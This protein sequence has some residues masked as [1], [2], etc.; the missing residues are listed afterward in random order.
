MGVRDVEMPHT[1]SRV[2]P[3]VASFE[4]AVS[5]AMGSIGAVPCL[6]V[7][8]SGGAD[9]TAMLVSLSRLCP[10]MG[11]S[12]VC[13]HISHGLRPEYEGREDAAA[14]S[15]LCDSLS[16]SLSI[17][18]AA[19]G[20]ISGRSA[21]EGC[22]IEAAA[23]E[24]RM[25]ALRREADRLGAKRIAV[26]HTRDDA[27]EHVLI[28]VLRGSGPAG[29]AAMPMERG[30]LV[31]PL[32]RLGRA[33]VLAYLDSLGIRYRTDST[34]VDPSFLRNRVRLGLVPLL[35]T[36]FPGWQGSIHSLAR[37]QARTAEFLSAEAEK[38][39]LWTAD[40]RAFNAFA[41]DEVNFFSQA[42]ILR[43]EALFQVVDA[44]LRLDTH[45]TGCPQAD[46]AP[47]GRKEPRREA[48]AV[49]ASGTVKAMDLGPVLVERRDSR[50]VATVRGGHG[51]ET[52]FAIVIREPG[53]LE[54]DG[55]CF[56]VELKET[57][58]G[59]SCPSGKVVDDSDGFINRVGV[60]LPFVIRSCS[61]QDRS[62]VRL[63]N[64]DGAV[65]PEPFAL[66]EDSGG[67]A[68]LISRD[69][70]GKPVLKELVHKDRPAGYARRAFF[71]IL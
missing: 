21:T 69:R 30:P 9:S 42:P 53:V 45:K 58:I 5:L 54:I 19:P 2:N 4:A 12:L 55:T 48:I 35:D 18:S 3:A 50:I 31:R 60:E 1:S 41:T 20:Y 71:S 25:D 10:Q 27:L 44:L 13:V 11:I 66:V 61:S 17:I 63:S 28:R 14:V 36:D 24:F 15:S 6:A 67:I 52:G 51:S 68:A 22:G 43:E 56:L 64:K 70:K 23:R 47:R 40:N 37:T 34:N 38:R 8:V 32:L 29:L 7:A 65:F 57:A 33:E 39:I 49:F 62:L 59:V 46:P 26:G 16:I